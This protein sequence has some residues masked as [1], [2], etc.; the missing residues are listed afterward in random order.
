[1]TEAPADRPEDVRDALASYGFDEFVVQ[2]LNPIET[3]AID[4]ED[5]QQAGSRWQIRT[6]NI[7]DADLTSLKQHLQE[8]VGEFWS[9]KSVEEDPNR[10]DAITSSSV[11]P[12]VGEE[13]TRA[14]FLAT[15]AVAV[16][17]LFFIVMILQVIV[18]VV[19]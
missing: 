6:E 15:L 17:V 3:D 19:F 18:Q 1:M 9:P 14:A 11:S 5:V 10:E 12:T 4:A 7:T 13:V 8:E 16:I 2:R